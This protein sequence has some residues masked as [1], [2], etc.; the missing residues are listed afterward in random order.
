M[1]MIYFFFIL[2]EIRR[3]LVIPGFNNSFTLGFKID[4]ICAFLFI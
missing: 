3:P 4:F 2:T 1:H